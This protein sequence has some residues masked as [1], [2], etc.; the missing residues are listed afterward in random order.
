MSAN[1]VRDIAEL[2]E[3]SLTRNLVNLLLKGG[4]LVGLVALSIAFAVMSEYFFTLSNWLNILRQ[5]SVVIIVASAQTMVIITSG[6][7]LSVGS[8][9]A[10]G[11]CLAAVAMSYWGWP[12]L[13]GALLGIFVAWMVGL[14]NGSIIAKGRIPDF[15]ATLGMLGAVRGVA[16]LITGGLPVPSHFTATELAGYLPPALIWLGSGH[17]GNIPVPIIVA[18]LIVLLTWFILSRTTLGRSIYAV[19]GNREAARASGID[20]DRVKI[21]V[22]GLSGL[23]CGLGGLVLVGRMNSA[24]A[25]MAEGLELQ[26]IAAVVIGG[27]NLFGGRGSVVG[28]LIGAILM[29]VL[30][31]GLNLLNVEPFWQRVVNGL[32]IVAIVVFDQWRRR[33]IK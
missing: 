7:D 27:T 11:G 28:T 18:L 30:A 4:S 26:T 3:A 33:L 23:Y 9:L 1:R 24:N 20:V 14:A 25:L 15:I 19:G 10:L 29:G 16:L 21:M 17:I 22:Y 32:L 12:F 13:S 31:N 6:I 2:E 8:L 5:V